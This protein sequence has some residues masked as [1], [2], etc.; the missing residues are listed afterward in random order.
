[1]ER[2]ALGLKIP[3]GMRDRLPEELALLEELERK[4]IDLLKSWSYKKVLTPALEYKACVEPDP[5]Q[6]DDLYKFFDKEGQILTLR[7]EFTTPIARMLTTRKTEESLPYRLCYSG[8]VF[9]NNPSRYREFRQI[10]VELVGSGFDIADAEVIAL[11]VELMRTL[12]VGNFQLNLGHMGIFTGLVEEFKIEE[13]LRLE[14]EDGIARKD[15]V[16]L[17]KTV[18][19][20]DLPDLCKQF[21][22]SMPHLTGKEDVLDKL[23]SWCK[24]GTIRRAVEA[25]RTISVF[26][27]EYGVKNSV[28]IDLGILRGFSYYTGVIF[29]GYIPGIGVPI[30]EGGRYDGLY[31]DFGRNLP[32]TGFAVNLDMVAEQIEEFEQSSVD[33]LVFGQSPGEVIKRTRELR[34]SGK[35]VEMA[36]DFISEQDALRLASQKGIVDV[37]NVTRFQIRPKV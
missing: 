1:M 8:D 19:Q 33:V 5:N 7:P 27:K 22:L 21:I 18:S 3:E 16:K 20:S 2:S 36:L 29:E 28:L 32:A 37:E 35:K 6:P 12:Q 11:A 9:R 15:M 25:L 31:A 26:L 14:L 4:G 17:E 34:R 30:L 24:I 13:A 10:G 23:E